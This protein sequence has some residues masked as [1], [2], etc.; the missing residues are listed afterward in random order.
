[1]TGN[2][3]DSVAIE[4][5]LLTYCSNRALIAGFGE[6]SYGSIYRRFVIGRFQPGCPD[7]DLLNFNACSGIQGLRYAP[8]AR[9]AMHAIDVQ[10]ELCHDVLLFALMI[11]AW[12]RCRP[13]R[14]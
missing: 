11:R 1:M 2:V 13:A 8:D 10:Y 14:S 4:D 9:A 3:R 5:I 6:S 12:N 7:A